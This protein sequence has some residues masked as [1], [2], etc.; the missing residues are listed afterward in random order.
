MARTGYAEL[1]ERASMEAGE[2]MSTGRTALADRLTAVGTTLLGAILAVTPVALWVAWTATVFFLVVAVAIASA[3]L[4]VLLANLPH[5]A[6]K[7]SPAVNGRVVLSD[8]FIAEAHKLFPL[9]YHHSRLETARFRRAM[10][11]LS[12]MIKAS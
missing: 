12:R 9:T 7:Q 6:A 2:P 10:E 1:A 5:Q 3:G 4:L 8:E 11:K